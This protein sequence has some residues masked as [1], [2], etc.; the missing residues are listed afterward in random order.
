MWIDTHCHLNDQ[1]FRDDYQTALKTARTAGV[2]VLVVVG[3]DLE[4]SRRAAQLAREHESIFAAVGIHPSDADT[5]DETVARELRRL[6]TEPKV[7]AL[8]EIGLDYHYDDAPAKVVQRRV[9]RQQLDLA[10]QLQKPVII[11]NREAHQDTWAVLQETPLGPAGGVMHCFSGSRETARQYLA[12]G[13][14]LSFAGPLTFNN[15]RQVREVAREIPLERLLIETDAPYL[16]PHP[17]R[18]QRNEPGLVGLVGEKLAEVK[19]L[20]VTRVMEVT[21]ANAQALFGLQMD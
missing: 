15:A 2:G 13:L 5:W 19:G 17:H 21:T 16:A 9:F 14:Y 6:L 18:G 3:F 12:M 20:A 8:G 7:V 10:G 1:A 4:S 11:H